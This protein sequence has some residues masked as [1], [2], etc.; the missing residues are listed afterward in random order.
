MRFDYGDE[1]NDLPGKLP[2][3]SK[4]LFPTIPLPEHLSREFEAAVA[5]NKYLGHHV[6]MGG[7]G[8]KL[9]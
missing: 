8:C 6:W 3:L 7:K 5:N 2:F 1:C 4:L 9:R